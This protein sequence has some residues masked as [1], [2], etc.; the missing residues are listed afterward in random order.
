MRGFFCLEKSMATNNLGSLTLDLVTRIGNFIEPLNQA[1]RKAKSS[2]ESIASSF[3]VASIAAKAFGAVL[4]GASVAGV[5]AF[6]TKAI[7]AGNEIK[8]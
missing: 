5:T 2:G 4:A 6:V 1:E 8:N 3:N 7:D